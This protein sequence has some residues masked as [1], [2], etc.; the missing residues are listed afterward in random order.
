MPRAAGSA[1]VWTLIRSSS[2]VQELDTVDV[3][4][5]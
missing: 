4:S 3:K 1:S 2:A 5:K